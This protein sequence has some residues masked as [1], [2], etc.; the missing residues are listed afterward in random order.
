MLGLRFHK[1]GLGQTGH[2]GAPAVINASVQGKETVVTQCHIMM[3][4]LVL[5]IQHKINLAMGINVVQM[6]LILLGASKTLR[7]ME[8]S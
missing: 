6:L 1:M 5:E 7:K 2:H 3:V 4:F 8:T